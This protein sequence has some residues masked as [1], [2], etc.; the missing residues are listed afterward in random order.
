MAPN[1][2]VLLPSHEGRY[3]ACAMLLEKY[4]PQLGIGRPPRNDALLGHRAPNPEDE[5]VMYTAIESFFL[6]PDRGQGALRKIE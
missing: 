6:Q 4:S 2:T 1:S 3:T 5:E